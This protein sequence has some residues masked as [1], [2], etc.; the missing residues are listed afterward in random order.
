MGSLD[1]A[2]RNNNAEISSNRRG[3]PL[4]NNEFQENRKPQLFEGRKDQ[5]DHETRYKKLVFD[6]LNEYEGRLTMPTNVQKFHINLLSDLQEP[7]RGSL[8]QIQGQ[9]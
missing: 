7:Y 2:S 4:H 6:S 5:D 9:R 3:N 8:F 1:L